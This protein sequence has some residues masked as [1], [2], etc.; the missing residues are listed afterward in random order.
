MGILAVLGILLGLV[1][2]INPLIGV[3]ALPFIL[4]IFMLI[5]GVGAVVQAFRIRREA[6]TELPPRVR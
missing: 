6:S 3:A 4:G 5:G 1:L 2:V